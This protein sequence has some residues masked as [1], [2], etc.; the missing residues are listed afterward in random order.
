MSVVSYDEQSGV[1]PNSETVLLTYTVPNGSTLYIGGFSGTGTALARYR[2]FVGG[3]AVLGYRT[4]HA[5]RNALV[6][7]PQDHQAGG[8][9]VVEIKVTSY[10]DPSEDFEGSLF[11]VIRSG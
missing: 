11:G 10:G 3:S 1:G 6:H 2:L 4:S 5:D 8:G 9:Q 7:F